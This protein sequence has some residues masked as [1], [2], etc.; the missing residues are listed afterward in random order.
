MKNADGGERAAPA[1]PQPGGDEPDA[2]G[3]RDQ[4]RLEEEVELRHAEVELG[5]EGREADQEAAA[6]RRAPEHQPERH[7]ALAVLAAEDALGARALGEQHALADQRHGRAADQ[8]QVRRAPQRHVLA[9]QPVPE[10]VEREADQRE[11]AGGRHQQAAERRVPAVVEADRGRARLLPRDRHG[12]EAR[13]EDAEQAEEDQ[14]VRRVRERARV[15]AVVDV[16]GDVPVHAEQRGDERAGAERGGQ[17]DPRRQPADAARVARRALEQLRAAG[18]V[19]EA[20]REEEGGGDERAA[21]GED[22]LGERGAAGRV[23]L[24]EGGGELRHASMY[25]RMTSHVTPVGSD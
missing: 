19:A 12:E 17:R 24:G 16:Q 20:E 25:H 8:H 1:A 5:L 9:E 4:H 10:V 3:E 15:A 7:T 11:A 23:S 2:R 18:A 21:G 13:G 14:V 6:E 22:D